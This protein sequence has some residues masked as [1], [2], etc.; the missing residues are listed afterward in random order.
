MGG[1][2]PI[3]GQ[4]V[5]TYRGSKEAFTELLGNVDESHARARPIGGRH[6]IWEIV[7]HC[8]FWVE[9]A[10]GAINGLEMPARGGDW[11]PTGEGEEEWSADAEKFDLAVDRLVE[12]VL[13]FDVDKVHDDV[14]GEHYPYSYF[15]MFFRVAHHNIHHGGQIAILRPKE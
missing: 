6:T 13:N 15:E 14:P 11:P 8:T 9:A 10:I 7:N 4:W 3:L 5:S 1:M 12:A 2:D